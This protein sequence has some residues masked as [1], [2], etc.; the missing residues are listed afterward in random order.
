MVKELD[1]YKSKSGGEIKKK[2]TAIDTKAKKEANA[3]KL[4]NNRLNEIITFKDEKIRELQKEIDR[5]KILVRLD[6]SI[7]K[8]TS[9][10]QNTSNLEMR[11][12]EMATKG[13]LEYRIVAN[14]SLD[15]LNEPLNKILASS[16]F[17][18]MNYIK[19]QA[20]IIEKGLNNS[21]LEPKMKELVQE[22]INMKT[23]TNKILEEKE[24]LLKELEFVNEEY[25]KKK[26]KL[27]LCYD[28]CNEVFIGGN[29]NPQKVLDDVDTIIS[30]GDFEKASEILRDRNYILNKND[31]NAISK[32]QLVCRLKDKQLE[33]LKN[34]SRIN[35]NLSISTPDVINNKRRCKMSNSRFIDV[36]QYP[37]M[38]EG[39]QGKIQL[40]KSCS[41]LANE[42]IIEIEL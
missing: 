41:D 2:L 34:N 1:L 23:S 40:Q 17:S 26:V 21:R 12:D 8:K 29:C 39:Y 16:T 19:V 37:T 4:D 9:A 35:K 31:N 11:A 36:G 5:F 3:L 14:H 28:L 38:S 6:S 15:K 33:E 7:T 10:K 42:K 25:A 18:L 22:N 24:M 30:K 32:L 13:K 27:T 20:K